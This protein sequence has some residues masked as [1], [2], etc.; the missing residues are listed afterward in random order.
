MARVIVSCV[1]LHSIQQTEQRAEPIEHGA[2]VDIDIVAT[3]IRYTGEKELLFVFASRALCY[4]TVLALDAERARVDL[5]LSYPL[6][7]RHLHAFRR[8]FLKYIPKCTYRV[9]SAHDEK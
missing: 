9:H 5:V 7:P 1:V 2:A 4:D 8:C 3:L 6:F